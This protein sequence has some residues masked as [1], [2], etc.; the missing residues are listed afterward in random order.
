MIEVM[1]VSIDI[2]EVTFKRL[3]DLAEG[4]DT[5]DLVINRLIDQIT[6]TNNPK[7]KLT[8]EPSDEKRFLELLVRIRIAEV[9]LYK[10]DGTRTVT[11]W[12][13]NKLTINSNLRGNIWSGP[14]RGWKEKG[15]VSAQF[16]INPICPKNNTAKLEFERDRILASELG[17]TFSEIKALDE[18]YELTKHIDSEGRV[19]DYSIRL[20]DMCDPK[21][22][23]Y[24]N[25]LDENNTLK[26]GSFTHIESIITPFCSQSTLVQ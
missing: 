15:L 18:N 8:F 24:V 22:L 2:E 11:D 6:N 20:F 21:I 4:F 3:S 7:P 16:T 17:L 23:A 10:E 12:N 5:P 14:L 9:A 25:G 26:F 19:Y 1:M 13:A